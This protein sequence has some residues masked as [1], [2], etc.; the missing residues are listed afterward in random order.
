MPRLSS[1]RSGDPGDSL[2]LMPDGTRTSCFEHHELRGQRANDVP[3]RA[4]GGELHN[5]AVRMS[6]NQGTLVATHAKAFSVSTALTVIKATRTPLVPRCGQGG[7][8]AD[9]EQQL[10]VVSRFILPNPA[11]ARQTP[12][13]R[14]TVSASGETRLSTS[15]EWL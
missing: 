9:G 3:P 1:Q 11:F 5:L 14:E 13:W 4:I 8:S 6:A 15:L 10:D 2:C 7:R 12:G